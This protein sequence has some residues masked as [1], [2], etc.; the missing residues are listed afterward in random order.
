[1]EAQRQAIETWAKREG[2]EVVAW[3]VEEVSGGAPLDKRPVLL[4]ALAT[5]GAR[6]A[7]VFVVHRLDRFSREP[8]TAALAEA[9]LRRHGATLACADGAGS[10]EDPTAELVR[11]ILLSVARFE[12]A[13]IRARIKSA[14]AV[15]KSRGEYLGEAPFGR[16]VADDGRTLVADEHE[17]HV[18]DVVRELRAE[19]LSLRA[20]V[21]ELGARGLVGRTGRPYAL[22]QVQ[23]M[24]KAA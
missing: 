1:V 21:R 20:V 12:K 13:M 8:L 3:F 7:G 24:A 16:R 5:V 14:L 22:A 6:R 2:V 10:G 4:D 18:L 17:A 15:K 23:R 11:G 19:R 9:E